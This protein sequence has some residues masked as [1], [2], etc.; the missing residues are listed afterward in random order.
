M[1]LRNEVVKLVGPEGKPSNLVE[2]IDKVLS[3]PDAFPDASGALVERTPE[4]YVAAARPIFMISRKVVLVDPFFSLKFK[5]NSG[6]AW[7][8]DRRRKV[9]VQFLHE[10]VRWKQ[11]E[12]FE[13]FYSPSKTGRSVD[14][15]AADFEGVAKEVGAT[16]IAIRVHTLDLNESNRQHARYLLGLR[17]GLHFDHGFDV[18]DDRSRNHVEWVSKTVLKTLLDK[19][20]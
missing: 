15:Q 8:A 16:R 7:L 6:G 20:T 4:A 14:S 9:L 1:S 11:V 13:I 17:N 2:P 10:A 18:S 5:S 3:D 12:A 19:F